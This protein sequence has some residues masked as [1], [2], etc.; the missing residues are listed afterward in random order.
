MFANF[1]LNGPLRIEHTG[2]GSDD[3]SVYLN[4][5]GSWDE[6]VHLVFIDQ[7]VGTGFSYGEPVPNSMDQSADEFVAFFNKFF[8]KYPQFNNGRDFYVAGE[9]YA[10]KYVPRYTY[11]LLK[12][13]ERLGTR[14]FNVKASFMG[15]PFTAPMT[16]RTHMHVVPEALNVLDDS[17]M[18]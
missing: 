14:K 11:A 7:P 9:S 15:D 13:N 16:Q 4:P 1:L 12:E 6:I 2:T 5:E 10:G 3:Y 8:E 18:P 17:N